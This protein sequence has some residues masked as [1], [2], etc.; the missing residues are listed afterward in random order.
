MER[1]GGGRDNR[2]PLPPPGP[3]QAKAI[4][5]V[6][7]RERTLVEWSRL[8]WPSLLPRIR[9]IAFP[10]QWSILKFHRR[11]EILELVTGTCLPSHVMLPLRMIRTVVTLSLAIA[12]MFQ[13]AA[14]FASSG[15][16]STD[17]SN[18][19]QICTGCGCCAV[20]TPGEA[21]CC[22]HSAEDADT[23]ES[24]DLSTPESS[25]EAWA[26]ACHCGVH[27]PPMNRDGRRCQTIRVTVTR[28]V[29]EVEST[30]LYRVGLRFPVARFANHSSGSRSDFSQRFL[31]VWRI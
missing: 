18:A 14:A 19:E 24:V 22:C 26:S 17:R 11:R 6:V 3:A 9:P 31:G 15:W 30:D 13:P 5:A 7:R 2:V 8:P 28:V 20:E 21:C 12:T 29:V 27:V 16:S 1:A 25:G 23:T 10:L 4:H